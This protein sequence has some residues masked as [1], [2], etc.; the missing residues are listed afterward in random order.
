VLNQGVKRAIARAVAVS[1][2]E[3]EIDILDIKPVKARASGFG[4]PHV[5]PAQR[6]AR[7][8]ADEAERNRIAGVVDDAQHL[9]LRPGSLQKSGHKRRRLKEIR[10]RPRIEARPC[11]H[12][13]GLVAHGRKISAHHAGLPAAR[14]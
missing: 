2:R 14:R 3:Q 13:R 4:E 8:C 12:Q 1:R 7:C 9:H 10:R 5:A 11:L 6:A